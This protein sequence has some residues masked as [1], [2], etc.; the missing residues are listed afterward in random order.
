MPM[1]VPNFQTQA[2]LT[3]YHRMPQDYVT[4]NHMW[5]Y[6]GPVHGCVPQEAIP[7]K[8]VTKVD[9]DDCAACGH[10]HSASTVARAVHTII[11]REY[12]RSVFPDYVLPPPR[13]VKPPGQ[14]MVC[15]DP[16]PAMNPA[17]EWD[18]DGEEA[19]QA[20]AAQGAQLE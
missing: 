8:P 9:Q 12:K 16:T 1:P 20:P 3:V 11:H 7:T 15:L 10:S 14:L 13:N 17:I 5:R 18:G 2:P 19:G 6:Q 4:Q